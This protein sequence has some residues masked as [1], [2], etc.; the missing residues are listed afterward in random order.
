[1][2]T[3]SRGRQAA[4]AVLLVLIAVAGWLLLKAVDETFATG[5]GSVA[6]RE[7]RD[8]A[9]DVL[10]AL[11]WFGEDDPDLLAKLRRA[12]RERQQACA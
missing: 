7:A 12:N 5:E 4:L 2:A 1:M 9:D 6:C 11:A 10:R 8:H 3:W